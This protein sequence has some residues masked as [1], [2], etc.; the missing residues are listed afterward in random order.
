M[1][2]AATPTRA[3]AKRRTSWM[4]DCVSCAAWSSIW[5]NTAFA[6][7]TL[8]SVQ[9]TY[10]NILH[11]ALSS[12]DFGFSTQEA[13]VYTQIQ[14]DTQL[15][16]S[17]NQLFAGI[18]QGVGNTYGGNKQPGAGA[19]SARRPPVLP[20]PWAE[21]RARR[22][23]AGKP[24]LVVGRAS[25]W[26]AR[27]QICGRALRLATCRAQPPRLACLPTR[28]SIRWCPAISRRRTSPPA[29]H[30]EADHGRS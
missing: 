20:G 8:K 29:I 9:G 16:Q 11:Q 5:G 25:A 3:R 6:E 22:P 7:D 18:A 14:G 28:R 23:V 2:Q 4:S 24:R 12:A 10:T 1:K 19:Q 27:I 13:A 30:S 21:W 17:L 15:A 26:A